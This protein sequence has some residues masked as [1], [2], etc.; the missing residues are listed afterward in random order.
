MKFVDLASIHVR[1]GDGGS[2]IISF[3]REKYVPKGGPDGGN[4]GRGGSVILR[5]N[6]HLATLLDF[7]YKR[8]YTAPTGGHG[9]GSR[10][11]GKSGTDI[12]VEVPEGTLVRRIGTG[13]ILVDLLKHG[14]EF[15]AARGGRGGR[16][17]SE[18]ATST[19]QAPRRYEQGEPG[20]ELEIELEL[21]LLADVGLVGLPNA[22]KSTL[23]SVISAARPKIAD[24]P[25]TTLVPNLG[26][27]R[28][29]EGKSFVVAD[30]PGLIEGAHDGKGLGLQFLRHVERT[31]VLVFLL[32]AT[33]G[34]LHEDYAVLVRELRLYN[35]ALARRKSLIAITKIDALDEKTVRQLRRER[36][37]RRQVYSISAVAGTGVRDLVEA[38]WK[39]L[40][41][42]ERRTPRS[43]RA[44]AGPKSR[45]R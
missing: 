7:Q 26:I 37:G 39:E 3:R 38:L 6:R 21:K 33:R 41:P 27:V 22:G 19:D 20:E 14:D 17:N 12:V 9:M 16:G 13:E 28:V 1:A 43:P 44:A 4:G 15:Q 29:D 34:T 18:F 11:T 10:K 31:R 23:I 45:A 2:G 25:F 8:S 40:Q 30:I 35:A 42:R 36:F 24:Y 5:A 32:D